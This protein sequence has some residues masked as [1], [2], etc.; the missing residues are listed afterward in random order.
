MN[1][2]LRYIRVSTNDQ[3]S[4]LQMQLF[5]TDEVKNK[6]NINLTETYIDDGISGGRDKNGQL[7]IRNGFDGLKKR[8]LTEVAKENKVFI[9]IYDITRIGRDPVV[10]EEFISLCWKTDTSTIDR[11][12]SIQTYDSWEKRAFIRSQFAFAT[13][14]KEKKNEDSMRGMKSAMMQGRYILNPRPGQLK[15][16][17]YEKVN[18]VKVIQVF[19][20]EASI[21]K[22]C[23]EMYASGSLDTMTDVYR[24]LKSNNLKCSNN[25]PYIK[26]FLANPVYAGYIEYLEWGVTFRKAIHQ[27]IISLETHY[28]IKERLGLGAEQKTNQKKAYKTNTEADFPLRQFVNCN[29]CK[30]RMTACWVRGSHKKYKSYFCRT[31]DCKYYRKHINGDKLE[32]EFL[33]VLKDSKLPKYKISLFIKLFELEWDF[34]FKNLEKAIQE[35]EKRIEDINKKITQLVQRHLELNNK[36]LSQTYEQEIEKLSIEKEILAE[37]IGN[38]SKDNVTEREKSRTYINFATI[39]LSN[40]DQYWTNSDILIKRAVQNLLFGEHFYYDYI[41]G[42]RTDE[43]S[44]I[45]QIIQSSDDQ[46]SEWWCRLPPKSNLDQLLE[47]VNFCRKYLD[48]IPNFEIMIA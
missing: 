5:T 21:V 30:K 23:L 33:E 35:K 6:L 36:I 22:K 19:E 47:L 32:A 12:A 3:E 46:K 41:L 7:K 28:K 45:S 8:V 38:M 20:P 4:G 15:G 25:F 27:P 2:Y 10:G 29:E 24:Y 48:R 37:Q 42:S 13:A 31:K 11:T 26:T 39:L 14:D 44:L 43:K 9:L 1:I 18:G 16:Y 40:P 34:Y 17:R